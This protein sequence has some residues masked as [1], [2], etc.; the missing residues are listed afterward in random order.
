[1]GFSIHNIV[2]ASGQFGRACGPCLLTQVFIATA[3]I[4]KWPGS[5]MSD[6]VWTKAASTPQESP[7]LK[8][9]PE[10]HAPGPVRQRHSASNPPRLDLQPIAAIVHLHYTEEAKASV[11]PPPKRQASPP[12]AAEFPPGSVYSWK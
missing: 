3:I 4:A 2:Y 8:A 10:S 1:V 12:Q 7:A 9:L 6:K 11:T 5:V